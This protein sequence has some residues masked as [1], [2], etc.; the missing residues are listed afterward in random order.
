MAT[1]LVVDDSAFDRELIQQVLTD[2]SSLT[3]E[4]A[5]NGSLA[6]ERLRAVPIDLVVSDLQ[7]PEMD[8]LEL[9]AMVRVHFPHVPVVLMTA[10]GSETLAMEALERGASS[11]VP[12]SQLNE[13]LPDTVHDV[14]ARTR[15]DRSYQQLIGC[16]DTTEFKLSL[17]NNV[18]LIDPL[19][20]LTQQI[21]TGMGLCDETGGYQVG[22][23]LR[24]SL[25]NALYRGNL[26]IS[27]EEMQEERERLLDGTATSLV[28]KRCSE[29][30]YRDRRIHVDLRV[31]RNEARFVIRDEG[32]GF[33]V[34]NLPPA[35]DP[36]ALEPT[37]GRGLVLMRALMDDVL[38]NEV[39]NEVTLVKKQEGSEP[40]Q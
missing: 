6:L 37:G 26:E 25:L 30:P 1:I 40:A 11:Y 21:A 39:G 22:V 35:G 15:A 4:L 16:F 28:A 38:F 7:M 36:N 29:S 33:D 3:V 9:V 10:H 23:A 31:E 5:E 12:K 8:G 18:E 19:V 13:K 32:P 14:L 27:R 20:D 2:D 17:D 34:A 24:E